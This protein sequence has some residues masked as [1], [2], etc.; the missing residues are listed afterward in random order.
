MSEEMTEDERLAASLR[1]ERDYEDRIYR[2]RAYLGTSAALSQGL[3]NYLAASPLDVSNPARDAYYESL[4]KPDRAA[5]AQRALAVESAGQQATQR[6]RG[7]GRQIAGRLAADPTKAAGVLEEATK[8]EERV[9]QQ[10]RLSAQTQADKAE[11]AEAVQ[12]ASEM[13]RIENQV[14]AEKEAAAEQKRLRNIQAAKDIA[15]AGFTLAAA[16]RPQTKEAQLESKAIQTGKR[17]KRL[18]KRLSD[19]T[20]GTEFEDFSAEQIQMAKPGGRLEGLA[21]RQAGAIDSAKKAET[22]LATYRAANLAKQRERLRALY[23]EDF[24]SNF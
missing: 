19:Q 14:Q 6:A 20:M 15:Q 2:S 21:K 13:E 12:R 18:D 1:S 24:A 11:A 4:S 17:A 5:E 7:V 22:D 10:A 9:S 23:G 3:F 8:Y 16:A